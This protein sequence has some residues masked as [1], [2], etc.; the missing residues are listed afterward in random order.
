MSERIKIESTVL[1]T[2]I[3]QLKKAYQRLLNDFLKNI[4]VRESSK[5]TYRRNLLQ[6]F[7]YLEDREIELETCNRA[8]I[9]EYK[10]HLLQ[11]VK[12]RDF[13]LLTADN[14]LNAVKI[15]IN[16]IYLEDKLPNFTKDFGQHISINAEYE[17]FKKEPLELDQVKLLLKSVQAT[18]ANA[19]RKQHE[20]A[21]TRNYAMI[22]LMIATGIRSITITRIL[23]EDMV[24]MVGT[25]IIHVQRKGR[26]DKDDFV[27]LEAEPYKILIDYLK[28]RFGVES[29]QH[30]TP[31]QRKEPLFV[32]HANRNRGGAISSDL[33]R[34]LIKQHLR[35]IGLDSKVFSAHSLRHT[36]GSIQL[37][38][39]KDIFQVAENMG[40]KQLRST[41]KYT[42]RQR[43]KQRLED[44]KGMTHLFK[45]EE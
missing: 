20:L 28:F 3:Y 12:N 40:H 8:I 21:Y 11:Q 33:I 37:K 22:Y 31:L 10:K 24:L 18:I 7:L 30:L 41:K 4:D 44:Y 5:R 38:L 45:E 15:F 9:L 27:I 1:N 32:S 19:T 2:T 42:A 43:R 16:W 36:Y 23:I 25:P 13:S 29:L 26:N 39:T 34:H 35:N 17:G 14:Y 6:F